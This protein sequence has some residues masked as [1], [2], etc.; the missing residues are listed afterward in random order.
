MWSGDGGTDQNGRGMGGPRNG[1]TVS[2]VVLAVGDG[3]VFV[4]WAALGLMH[5]EEGVTL[6]GLVRNAGPILVGWFAAALALRTYARP[7][8]ARFLATWAIGITAGVLLRSAVL[9]KPWNGD[10][11]AFLGVTLAVTLVM[12]LLW[13]GIV[14]AIGRARA[15]ISSA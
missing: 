7:G 9:T 14:L 3:L 1:T 6:A 13:R 8:L 4:L 10:E 11:F 5:H 15:S 12:L 2:P